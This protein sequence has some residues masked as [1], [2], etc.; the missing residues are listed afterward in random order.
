MAFQ[1]QNEF[2]ALVKEVLKRRDR[3]IPIIG[4]DCFCGYIDEG[5]QRRIVPLQEW[6]AIGLLGDNVQSETLNKIA[7][8]GYGGL[9]VLF[10]EYRLIN[11]YHDFEFKEAVVSLVEEG[12]ND[13]CVFLR[14]DVKQFLRAGKFEVI[15][16]T[17]PFHLLENE[18]SES[19]YKYNTCSFSPVSSMEVTKSSM[20]LNLPSIYQIFGDCD[21]D[22]VF[23]EEDLLKYLHYL[24]QTDTEKGY[25]ASPFV[26]YI[27]DKGQDNKGLGLLMPIG[28]SN[29]PNWLFRFLWYPFSPERLKGTDKLRGGV[30]CEYSKDEDFFRFLCKYKFKTISKSTELLTNVDSDNDPVL[31]KLTSEF[32]KKE[33]E[34]KEYASTN[35]RIQWNDR[36]EWDYFLSY[37]SEDVEIAER[38]YKILTNGCGK[39][40]WMDKR[41]NIKP[42]EMYWDAIM[43][44]IEKSDR[45]I[46]IITESYLKK[47]IDKNHMYDTGEIEPTG[48][49]KE[50]DLI[51][52]S[53]LIKR[54]DDKK[55]YYI[56]LV[57]KGTKVTYT[58]RN[59]ILHEDEILKNGI[60]EELP[61]YKEYEMLQTDSLFHK[62]QDIVC[63]TDKLEEELISLFKPT[64]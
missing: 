21:G 2:D 44:G 60:L 7:H 12:I 41:G 63:E 16:T 22:F 30:W 10:D 46:F 29:L 64:K 20:T 1:Q 58:D 55:G 49:Y 25:G 42:G 56:P 17:C 62:I 54:R 31:E 33:I 34:L 59:G 43:H 3:I 8:G 47:A 35:L 18:L 51:R 9:D 37:A 28:C 36:D 13:N 11:K 61:K 24:N 19:N 57:I 50:I 5:S 39:T 27:K 52:Q 53:F 38:V 40:V 45:F 4:D 23:G 6:I 14:N 15:A 48:V 32:V 26:K